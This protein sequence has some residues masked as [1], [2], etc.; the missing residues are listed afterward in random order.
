MDQKNNR[1]ESDKLKKKSYEADNQPDSAIA[2]TTIT[3]ISQAVR[4]ADR[5][6]YS[7]HRD[8]PINRQC[9][10]V[11]MGT[12]IIV[13]LYDSRRKGTSGISGRH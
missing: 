9:R 8:I 12:C 4:L 5:L 2:N 6:V 11:F 13:N 3:Q 1:L 10:N 7:R